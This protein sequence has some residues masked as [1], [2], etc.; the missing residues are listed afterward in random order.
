MNNAFFYFTKSERVG[1][2]ALLL[3][4]AV[5]FVLPRWLPDSS[6]APPVDFGDLEAQIAAWQSEIGDTTYADDAL[7]GTSQARSKASRFHPNRATYELLQAAGLSA[8][9]CR[10]WLAYLN[11]GGQ[12]R[13]WADVE[14]FRSLTDA[15]R[16]ALRPLL[17]FDAPPKADYEKKPASQPVTIALAPFDPNTATSET[18]EQMGVPAKTARNWAKFLASGARFKRPEDVRKI[19]GMTDEDFDRIAPYIQLSDAAQLIAQTRGG[20]LPQAYGTKSSSVIIDINQA[21]AE[22]WQQ[23]KGIGPGYSKRIVEQR[24]KLGGFHRVEQVAEVYGLPDSVFQNIYLQLR[25]SPILRTIPINRVSVEELAAH[26][27]INKTNA[28]LIIQYRQQHGS[29]ATAADLDKL[30]G[31]D[32]AAKAKIIPYLSFD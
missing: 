29:Y 21:T 17:Y 30:Y 16:A 2:V 8:K 20:D 4:C 23:L 24:E 13:S 12:F 32:A 5:L 10:S 18:L 11:K 27:Y 3:V 6:E 19:Y 25:P 14:K 28:R 7:F 26:P 1:V 22:Q 15:D 9:A 31:L